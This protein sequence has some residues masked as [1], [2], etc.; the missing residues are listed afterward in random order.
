[1]EKWIKF[2]KDEEGVTAIEYGLLAT[3][4]AIAAIVAM[5]NVGEPS[6]RCLETSSPP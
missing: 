6:Q 2:L 5:G 4:I 3:L 1:M